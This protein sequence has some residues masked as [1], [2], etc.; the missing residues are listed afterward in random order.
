M[1]T[2]GQIRNWRPIISFGFSLTLLF[3]FL[4]SENSLLY[5]FF[6]VLLFIIA[7][8]YHANNKDTASTI[9][10][11]TDW[12][13]CLNIFMLSYLN[14]KFI[15]YRFPITW[16]IGLLVSSSLFLFFIANYNSR[17]IWRFTLFISI[18]FCELVILLSSIDVATITR[19]AITMLTCFT[20][21]KALR[22]AS[23]SNHHLAQR[24]LSHAKFYVILCFVLV[25]T[26]LLNYYLIHSVQD[27]AL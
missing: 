5:Q 18:L 22:L 2:V 10:Y 8:A 16:Q 6:T 11:N 19:A 3:C 7:W 13:L 23:L 25:A 9:E 20:A 15:A 24:T 12:S 1:L 26:L 4:Y 17:L 14:L 27:L 21:I